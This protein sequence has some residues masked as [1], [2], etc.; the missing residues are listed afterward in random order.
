MPL[1]FDG[2]ASLEDAQRFADTTRALHGLEAQVF[3]SAARAHA[4]DPFPYGLNPPVVHIERVDAGALEHEIEE[5][6]RDFGGR[7]AG[8]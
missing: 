1:I 4:I 6:V 3:S 8:T 2:F 5:S 7:F